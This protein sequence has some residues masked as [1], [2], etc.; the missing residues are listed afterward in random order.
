[1]N[2]SAGFARP[3]ILLI[4]A[5]HCRKTCCRTSLPPPLPPP[6]LLTSLP[7]SLLP[8]SL[9]PTD[10]LCSCRSPHVKRARPRLAVSTS[11]VLSSDL[12]HG[13]SRLS[14]TSGEH[15]HCNEDTPAASHSPRALSA[16]TFD[17]PL[18]SSPLDVTNRCQL[19][20]VIDF[21]H[22]WTP[23]RKIDVGHSSHSRGSA[24]G[25]C[26]PLVLWCLHAR[27]EGRGVCATTRLTDGT[28]VHMTS[29]YPPVQDP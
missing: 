13:R 29:T 10:I 8:S 11:D 3:L 17:T 15:T 27:G 16:N 5:G 18:F 21:A 22:V 28:F 20:V 25:R 12:T 4:L 1:M 6:S 24:A 2:K 14:P 9:F 7:P 19:L 26:T 23:S